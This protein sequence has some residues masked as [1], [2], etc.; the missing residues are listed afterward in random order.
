MLSVLLVLLARALVLA[1]LLARALVLAVLLVLLARA[2]VLAVLLV[3]ALMLAVLL[4]RALV[5]RY[6]QH[7]LIVL[8]IRTSLPR[9]P[10]PQR[11][12]RGLTTAGMARPRSSRLPSSARLPEGGSWTGW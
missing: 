11:R 4:V 9:K 8:I 2:L 12:S 3:R 1:V 5:C 10:L 6:M 7:N